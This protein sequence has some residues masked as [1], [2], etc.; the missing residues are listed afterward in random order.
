[1][2]DLS[3]T[4]GSLTFVKNGMPL[5]QAYQIPRMLGQAG[6]GPAGFTPLFPHVMVKNAV[7]RVDF[8]GARPPALPMQVPWT[9]EL[10]GFLPWQVGAGAGCCC[11]CREPGALCA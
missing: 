8:M 4:P 3:A 7:V 9:G 5:G 1:M 2:V 11:C 6:K 10:N